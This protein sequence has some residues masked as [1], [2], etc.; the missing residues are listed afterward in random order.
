MDRSKLIDKLISEGFEFKTLSILNDKQLVLLS[1]RVLSEQTT[2]VPPQTTVINRSTN[3]T[4]NVSSNNP[5]IKDIV[6]NLNKNGVNVNV[7]E[8]DKESE[9]N[10]NDELDK[11]EM[12]EW[13]EGLVNEN[14]HPIT[15]KGEITSLIK[16]KLTE[17]QNP[18]EKMTLPEDTDDC[19]YADGIS[20]EQSLAQKIAN[21]NAHN[22][23]LGKFPNMKFI[24][25]IET[26]HRTP[27]GEYR[28]VVGLK[29]R[30]EV[31]PDQE[32]DEPYVKETTKGEFKEQSYAPAR[33]KTLPGTKPGTK[34]GEKIKPKTPYEPGRG[35]NPDKKASL[36][37]WLK[38]D[39]IKN[40]K[41]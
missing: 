16:E 36:P 32:V 3:P 25:N 28:Y 12:S 31:G 37:S 35:T 1:T 2:T 21:K 23:F 8:E 9:V 15:T 22:K 26:A 29:V 10:E 34:P 40:K 33:P 6:T 5:K 20:K 24:K 30:N 38:F 39:N 7:T 13:V 19:V 4:V 18:F 11:N 17:S 14:Y 27:T 41:L